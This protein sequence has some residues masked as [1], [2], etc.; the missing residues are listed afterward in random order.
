MFERRLRRANGWSAQQP[1]LAEAAYEQQVIQDAARRWQTNRL[2]AKALVLFVPIPQ[3]TGKDDDP[4]WTRAQTDD[5]FVMTVEAIDGLRRRIREELNARREVW[6]Y[7]A[8]IGFGFLGTLAG[9]LT[10]LSKWL[11]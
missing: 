8:A 7:R 3:C 10:A 1:L 6:R 5:F 11:G 2:T 4:N 9:I